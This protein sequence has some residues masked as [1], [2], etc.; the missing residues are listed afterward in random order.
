MS[1][2]IINSILKGKA[3]QKEQNL[4]GNVNY[5]NNT[6]KPSSI[7]PKK[8]TIKTINSLYMVR[9]KRMFLFSDY[10]NFYNGL[11]ASQIS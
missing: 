2:E 7:K 3:Y 10:I 9:W 11:V 8:Q 5:L 6:R 4:V 1:N